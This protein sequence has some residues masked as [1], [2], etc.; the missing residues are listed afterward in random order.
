MRLTDR[1][2]APFPGVVYRTVRSLEQGPVL[3]GGTLCTVLLTLMVVYKLLLIITV[4]SVLK[5]LHF[6]VLPITTL[7]GWKGL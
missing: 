5:E 6:F 1:S 4:L 7:Q 3:C 2:T